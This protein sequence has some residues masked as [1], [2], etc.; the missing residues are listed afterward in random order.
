MGTGFG[1]EKSKERSAV[2]GQ[3]GGRIGGAQR[4][5]RAEKLPG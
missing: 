2:R 1:D 4:I 3:K 5:F